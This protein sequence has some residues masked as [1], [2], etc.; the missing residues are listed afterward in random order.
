MVILFSPLLLALVTTV[1]SGGAGVSGKYPVV[2]AL[3]QHVTDSRCLG[4]KDD[5][6]VKYS[7]C[8]AGWVA[9]SPGVIITA[10]RGNVCIGRREFNNAELGVMS[11]LMKHESLRYLFDETFFRPQMLTGALWCRCFSLSPDITTYTLTPAV[12]QRNLWILVRQKE[13]DSSV[14][15]LH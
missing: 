14:P 10:S 6:E 4:G 3:V 13:R 12:V 2:M 7:L 1:L 15:L 9:G 5:V 11:M 8:K